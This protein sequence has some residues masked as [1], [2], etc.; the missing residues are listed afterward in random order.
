MRRIVF[1]LLALWLM[2]AHAQAQDGLRLD[3]VEVV[4]RINEF[5]VENQLLEGRLVNRGQAALQNITLFAELFNVAGEVIG[6]GIG[7]PVNACGTGLIGDFTLQPGDQQR[8]SIAL[9]LYED[10]ATFERYE[11][12]PQV[13]EIDPTPQIDMEH[14]AIEAVSLEEVVSAEWIDPQTLAYGVGCE[15]DVFTQWQWLQYTIDS[16]LSIPIDAPYQEWMTQPLL[17]QLGLVDPVIF[18]RSYLAF[19]PDDTRLVYQTDINTLVTAERD[20]S[21]RRILYNDLA[22]FSLHGYLW[23][24][25][26]RFLAYYYG[27]YGD[28]VRYVTVSTLGQRISATIFDVTPS[29]TVPGPTPDGARVVITAEIE[30]VTGYYLTS[31]MTGASRLLFED[32]TPPGNNYPAPIY[33]ERPA[34]DA[35]IYLVRPLEDGTAE[36]GCY[37]LAAEELSPLVRLPLQLTTDDRGWMWLSPD[38]TRI[39]IAANGQNGGLWLI[40]LAQLPPCGEV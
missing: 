21:F 34:G 35:A 36:L 25:E 8:F 15:R 29:F 30:G 24:P 14:P 31:T 38:Q 12:D 5:G 28:P 32:P 11:I 6:E 22:R 3:G 33:V 9:E 7:Y 40:D 10:G 37:H 19:H 16:P 18:N 26:G 13:T 1:I 23:L 39:A 17:Q 27:A 4:T 2:T 20:G